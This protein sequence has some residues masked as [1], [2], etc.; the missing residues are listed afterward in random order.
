[1]I[2]YKLS[3]LTVCIFSLCSFSYSSKKEQPES[4]PDCYRSITNRDSVRYHCKILPNNN[5]SCFSDVTV[6]K[7]F[8]PCESEYTCSPL[9]KYNK[10]Y[11][12]QY[13]ETDAETLNNSTKNEGVL[14][15]L[16][17]IYGR[18]GVL[19]AL[20]RTFSDPYY[21]AT[22]ATS[23]SIFIS[24]ANY[25]M[26]RYAGACAI[27]LESNSLS[28]TFTKCGH[29]FHKSCLEQWTQVSFGAKKCPYCTGNI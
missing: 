18:Y 24:V 14:D 27:C 17:I 9:E 12:D 13:N 11:S 23:F 5:L 16:Y 15:I 19:N 2:N 26:S 6:P 22:V 4:F 21:W 7:N 20:H 10:P 1:M 3:K 29:A 28:S 8:K 25:F